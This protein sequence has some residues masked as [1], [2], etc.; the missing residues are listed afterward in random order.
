MAKYRG[1]IV[2]RHLGIVLAAAL[3]EATAAGAAENWFLLTREDG[4]IGLE[5]LA[6]HER[7]ARVPRDPQDFAAMMRERG[8]RVSVGLPDGFPMDLAG[9]AVMVRY[10]EDRAPVFVREDL[11]RGTRE[12]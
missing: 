12:R 10:R 7:L 4:C 1:K 6:R 8:H 5:L 3:A 2:R 11:C 9:R